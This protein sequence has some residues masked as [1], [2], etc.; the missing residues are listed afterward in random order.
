MDCPVC[1]KKSIPDDVSHCPQCNADLEPLRHIR[2]LR[3]QLHDQQQSI[4]RKLAHQQTVERTLLT[5]QQQQQQAIVSTARLKAVFPGV[6]LFA[7]ATLAGLVWQ[8]QVLTHLDAERQTSLHT[9]QRLQAQLTDQQHTP[10]VGQQAEQSMAENLRSL[11]AI[12]VVALPIDQHLTPG[13]PDRPQKNQPLPGN[14]VEID[15]AEGLF[16][17]GQSRLGS[18]ARWRLTELASA[19][20]RSSRS[21]SMSTG[22]VDEAGKHNIQYSN[23]YNNKYNNKYKSEYKSKYDGEVEGSTDDLPRM[24]GRR[25]TNAELARA[26]ADSVVAFLRP[27]TPT[28][29]WHVSTRVHIISPRRTTSGDTG[30][31]DIDGLPGNRREARNVRIFLRLI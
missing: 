30:T 6:V 29:R 8:Y 5:L 18:V 31:S 11:Y 10:P 17:S 7:L 26:R 12:H 16:A 14:Q 24:R 1:K 27:L 23:K 21:T 2:R 4:V 20:R 15:F 9:M 25:D 3:T 28:I 22:P 19:L 13:Q